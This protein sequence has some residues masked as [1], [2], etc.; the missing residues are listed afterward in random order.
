MVKADAFFF[1]LLLLFVVV[2]VAVVVVVVVLC[3]CVC[4]G[5]REFL[6]QRFS[7]K[8]LRFIQCWVRR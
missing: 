8:I 4:F 3:V 6:C 1:L 2:V 5:G 7:A